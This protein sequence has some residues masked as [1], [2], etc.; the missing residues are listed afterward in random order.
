MRRSLEVRDRVIEKLLERVEVLERQMEQFQREQGAASSSSSRSSVSRRAPLS[1]GE[2]EGITAA[3]KAMPAMQSDL[4]RKLPS[5]LGEQQDSLQM[6][7]E[8]ESRPAQQ[9]PEQGSGSNS[10]AIQPSAQPSQQTQQPGDISGGQAGPGDD[11]GERETTR[12]PLAA[13]ERGGN[14]LPP[15]KLQLETALSYAYNR[16]TR[17][18]FTGFSVIP[19]VILGTLE[20]EKVTQNTW[21]STFSMRY[22]VMKDLMTSFSLPISW[23]LQNRVRVSNDSVSLVSDDT[24]QFGIGDMQ[25]AI[26]YQPIYESGWLPDTNLS[27]Q[28]RAPTGRSQFDLAKDLAK[29]G[30]TFTID[31][32]IAQLNK[33]GLPTGSGFWG[34]TPSVSIVK[35]FDPG[36]LFAS[37]GY[38]FNFS[39]DATLV[40]IG[41]NPVGGGAVQFVPEAFK[42]N[43]GPG[44][45]INVSL[46]M[47]LSLNNQLSFNFGF[48]NSYTFLSKQNGIKVTDS[49]VNVSQFRA[50][51]TVAVTRRLTV[52]VAGLIGLTP[53]APNFALSVSLPLTFDS[54]K[55]LLPFRFG[56]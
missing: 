37:L 8:P 46:G 10:Q 20:S 28:L 16:T 7:A 47:A 12:V 27:L 14:L 22:G 51:F 50:G 24:N 1:D 15:G 5:I 38:T 33:Q 45:S 2:L 32:F 40:Q 55:D 6:A 18:I 4:S 35:G 26:T 42:A 52:D 19:I 30:P 21:G 53:D 34:L 3:G 36:V 9:T 49:N 43:V 48:L 13:V 41:Q 39:R 29:K 17:L 44:D 25:F 23:Q 31:D 56:S 11:E 54:P